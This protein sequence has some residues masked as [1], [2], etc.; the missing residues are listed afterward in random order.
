MV[1][2]RHFEDILL[3]KGYDFYELERSNTREFFLGGLVQTKYDSQEEVLKV[4]RIKV[5][6]LK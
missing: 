4:R 1:F 6:N 2:Y 3:D 5:I